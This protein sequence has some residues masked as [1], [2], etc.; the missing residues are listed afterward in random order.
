MFLDRFYVLISK[1]NFKKIKK[2]YFNAF[3][4]EKHFEKQLLPR[5]QTG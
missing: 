3:P 4:S 1:I 5:Y 2:H